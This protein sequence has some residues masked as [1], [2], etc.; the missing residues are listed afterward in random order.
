MTL[1]IVLVSLLFSYFTG[2]VLYRLFFHPLHKYPGPVLAVVTNWYEVY[3]NLVLGGEFVAEI[4][5]LH[6]LYGALFELSSIEL[7]FECCT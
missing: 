5:R 6:R 1:Y 2:L 3:Y 4:E 7:L